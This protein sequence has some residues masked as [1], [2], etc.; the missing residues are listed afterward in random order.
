MVKV[1]LR[2]RYLLLLCFIL[3]FA[4]TF[5]SQNFTYAIEKGDLPDDLRD[6]YSELN[7]IYYN[8][9]DGYEGNPTANTKSPGV[10]NG[11]RFV[12][13]D[14]GHGHWD[15]TTCSGVDS[16]D[17]ELKDAVPDIQKVAEEK[18]LPWELMAAQFIGEGSAGRHNAC[19]YNSLGLKN[20]NSGYPP[21]C[22]SRNHASFKNYE[23]A[24][25][26]YAEN[27]KAVREMQNLY[28]ED[29]YSGVEFLEY[30]IPNYAYAAS[31]TYVP[32]ISG[33]ICGI[34]KWAEKNNITTSAVTYKNW[35]DGTFSNKPNSA[36]VIS[37]KT[38]S[39]S[40]SSSSQFSTKTSSGNSVEEVMWNYMVNLGISGFSDNP[41]AIAGILGNAM[42][43]GTM[44]PY[45]RGYTFGL[46]MPSASVPEF[47]TEATA[48]KA[49]HPENEENKKELIIMVLDNLTAKINKNSRY[50]GKDAGKAYPANFEK[51]VNHV[52]E[53]TK[54]VSNNSGTEGAI[55]Y[56]D[57]FMLDFERAVNGNSR[58]KDTKVAAMDGNKLWQEM[59]ERE[60]YAVEYYNKY[61]NL[62][63]TTT[64][65]GNSDCPVKGEASEDNSAKI[66]DYA[67][68]YAWPFH[69]ESDGGKDGYCMPG[70]GDTL[71]KFDGV[72]DKSVCRKEPKP[73]YKKDAI[74]TDYT[75]C[76]VYVAT[77]MIKSGADPDYPKG[78]TTNSQK[79]YLEKEAADEKDGKYEK[80]SI[81]SVQPGDIGIKSGHTAIYVG[82]K[83][84][85]WSAM[86]QAS[87]GNSVPVLGQSNS[88]KG[89]PRTDLT[90]YRRKGSGEAIIPTSVDEIPKTVSCNPNSVKAAGCIVFYQSWIK[91]ISE[92][93]WGA[94]KTSYADSGC[95]PS[96]LAMIISNLTGKVVRP[97][98]IDPSGSY[99]KGSG[100]NHSISTL[101][102]NYG[103]KVEPF[104][105]TKGNIEKVIK[106]GGMIHICSSSG[107]KQKL[108]RT[109]HCIA[110]RGVTSG[111]KYLVFDSAN[112]SAGFTFKEFGLDELVKLNARGASDGYAIYK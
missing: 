22:D 38:S 56:A 95:G 19:P 82:D 23:E 44:N 39:N 1:I 98:E 40:S 112:K 84:D 93:P 37:S 26:Y 65:A 91:G 11:T 75:A 62:S 76:N 16:Y 6:K 101:A 12:S 32:Y 42:Q 78:D 27:I 87:H 68:K 2:N 107:S 72:Y 25:E 55:S 104:T 83:G 36:A 28:P 50:Y 29:P 59:T 67:L 8:P 47:N 49:S 94:G 81:D 17:K 96:S 70:A 45:V 7:I 86:A 58:M 46:I 4:F 110:V 89:K 90:Y 24:W 18:G 21:A 15:G 48:F 108:F 30:G 69:G 43:E 63:G 85:P 106:S 71:V 99:H 88:N 20:F 66:V 60:N 31:A 52:K 100:S 79:P 14:N 111:G 92:K 102:K 13:S 73:A 33:I 35:K 109:G 64:T 51:Y 105:W 103:L 97:D 41:S 9:C 57:L 74:S 77:V 54:I 10:D 5:L 80:V 53:G 61:Q 34:Q 3:T